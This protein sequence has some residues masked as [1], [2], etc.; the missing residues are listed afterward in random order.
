MS[1]QFFGEFL[2]DRWVITRGQLIEALELQDYRNLRFGEIAVQKKYLDE[3]QVEQ[4]NERQK[5]EDM[6]FADL[7][8]HM[9]LLNQERAQELLTYQKNNHLFL[10]E[11]LLELGHV[12]EDVLQQELAVFEEEQSRYVLEDVAVPAEIQGADVI[13]VSVDLTRKMFHRVVGI[14]IKVGAGTVVHKTDEASKADYH[15]SVSVSFKVPKPVKYVLSVSS[16]VA[17][18]IASRILKE[19]ATR[20]SEAVV[21]DAV[22]EFCNIVCGNAI[23]KLAQMGVQA[24]IA[25]PEP[26]PSVPE[27][28]QG[29]VAVVF[30]VRLAEGGLDLR[31]I[32]IPS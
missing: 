9:K 5:S 31:F 15:L 27:V 32:T 19:D 11:A 21:E 20:E 25:P 8:V 3:K 2:I 1:I 14:I 18:S 16:D 4:I 12:T 23:A 7:A 24:D 17:V 28:P 22:K 29:S 26:L 13:R 30:P 10:G 6:P